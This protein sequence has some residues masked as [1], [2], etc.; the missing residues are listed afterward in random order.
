M[1]P[2]GVKMLVAAPPEKE[3]YSQTY[4]PTISAPASRSRVITGASNSGTNPSSTDAPLVNGTPASVTSLGPR[5]ITP[6]Q[7]QRVA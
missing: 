7:N 6:A 2:R 3:K 4:L 1:T 5:G